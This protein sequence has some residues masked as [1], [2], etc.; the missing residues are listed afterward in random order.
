M[1]CVAMSCPRRKSCEHFLEPDHNGWYNYTKKTE[2]GT[3]LC[4]PKVN[5]AFYKEKGKHD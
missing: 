4:G 3:Y 1:S 5:Y 2:A